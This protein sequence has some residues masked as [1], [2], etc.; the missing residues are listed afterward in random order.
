VKWKKLLV[1]G[2]GGLAFGAVAVVAQKR[3]KKRRAEAPQPI[4]GHVKLVE[5]ETEPLDLTYRDQPYQSRSRYT[6]S[7]TQF[8]VWSLLEAGADSDEKEGKGLRIFHVTPVI[9]FFSQEGRTETV[10]EEKF[11]ATLHLRCEKSHRH[12]P[13]HLARGDYAEFHKCHVG[14]SMNG[15]PTGDRVLT[16]TPVADFEFITEDSSES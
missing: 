9:E 7:P 2:L 14:G 5:I 11:Y 16:T 1:T 13:E 3:R 4:P 10:A 8:S 15:V 12:L 6:C